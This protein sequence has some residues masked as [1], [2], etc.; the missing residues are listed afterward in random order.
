MRAWH[1]FRADGPLVGCEFVSRVRIVHGMADFKRAALVLRVMVVGAVILLVLGVPARLLRRGWLP[2]RKVGDVSLGTRAVG[3][4]MLDG[5]LLRWRRRW[6][7][8]GQWL[9]RWLRWLRAGAAGRASDGCRCRA[10]AELGDAGLSG[11][12]RKGLGG[13]WSIERRLCCVPPDLVQDENGN[14]L[15]LGLEVVELVL[16]KRFEV[17]KVLEIV[18]GSVNVAKL[19]RDIV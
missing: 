18:E 14:G 8:H 3:A 13:D 9:L 4:R 10:I 5:V 15:D 11:Q 2:R 19:G 12:R 1:A 16:L 6:R 17:Y 7:R